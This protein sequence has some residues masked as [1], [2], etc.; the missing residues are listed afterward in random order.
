MRIGVLPPYVDITGTLLDAQGVAERAR[1]IEAAGLDSLW[2]SDRLPLPG[3]PRL[4]GP[5]PFAY[6]ALAAYATERIELGTAI[7]IVSLRNKYDSAQRMFT[8][9]TFA[10]GRVTIGVGTGSQPREYDSVGV[11]WE[12]RFTLL[13]EG[14][15]AIRQV[16]AGRQVPELEALFAEKG[17]DNAYGHWLGGAF[18]EADPWADEPAWPVKVGAPRFVLGAWY[19]AAQLRRAATQFDGW[20]A[21]GGAGAMF[22]GWVKMRDAV[23]RYRDLGGGRALMTS[24]ECDL[25]APTTAL[26]EA[27][28]FHLR[29]GAEVATERL[30]ELEEIGFDDVILSITDH[31]STVLPGP[32][33]YDFTAE[34]LEEIRSLLPKDVRRP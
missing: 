28:A 17:T 22:G 15:L 7:H 8:L 34:V 1:M 32:R 12:Q 2:V 21:S 27:G 13:G 5:D 18:G 20:M 10:P 4:D 31:R 16:F 29:C 25:S 33:Q 14:M 3:Y 26:D 23:K 30:L 11:D 19:S 6:L 9:Q 24:V